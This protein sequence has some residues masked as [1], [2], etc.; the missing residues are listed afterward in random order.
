M[1]F[2]KFLFNCI[3]GILIFTILSPILLIVTILIL[4]VDQTNPLFIQDRVGL[5]GKIIS[6]FKFRTLQA[7]ESRGEINPVE[8]NDKRI[9]KLGKYLRLI[10]IDELPQ[11]LNVIKG[12]MNFIGPR[13]LALSQDEIYKKTIKN[14]DKRSMV[15]PGIT[16]LSQSLQINGGHNLKKYKLVSK[17]DLYYIRKKSLTL[18][19]K[20]IIKT[21]KTIKTISKNLI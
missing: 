5:K 13:P 10:H 16:G 1:N 7:N 20:I 14:W 6:V 21:I 18:D 15:K 4:I 19:F 17:L 11:I 9:T 12:D 8:E 2:I 3:A